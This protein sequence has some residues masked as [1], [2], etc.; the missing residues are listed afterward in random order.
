LRSRLAFSSDELTQFVS[1]RT[2]A[3]GT[4]AAPEVDRGDVPRFSIVMPSYNHGSLIEKSLLSVLN[5][6]YPDLELI[7]MDGGS[8]D[9]TRA[10]LDKYADDI[11]TWRSEPD[12]GQS[13]ALNKGFALATGEIFGWLNSDDIYCP[14]AL[15][16]AARVFRSRPEVQVVYGDWYTLGLDDRISAHYF[17]LPYSRRQLI[18]EGVFCNAQ[19]MFWRR[20]LHQR[21]GEFDLK[22]HYTMDYDLILRFT[23]L[24][25]ARGFHRTLEPLGCFRVYPGQKTGAASAVDTVASEHLRIA[26]RENT[27]WK[28]AATGRALRLWYRAKRV[29]DYY[30][31]GGSAYVLWKLGMARNPVQ[32]A[33]AARLVRV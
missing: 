25:G 9:G 21:F 6:G 23:R 2:V 20:E 16:Y 13:D 31:R 3:R 27:T 11:A 28:Y 8:R 19:A 33:D 26:Q 22:L 29:R 10:I 4:T 5:Q 7:V 1:R 12:R 24:A 17:G 32:L 18:T 14:G 30:R 15:A